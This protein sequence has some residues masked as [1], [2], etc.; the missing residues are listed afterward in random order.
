MKLVKPTKKNIHL[1]LAKCDAPPKYPIDSLQEFVVD[2][3]FQ[4]YRD[5]LTAP[6]A[7]PFSQFYIRSPSSPGYI[8]KRKYGCKNKAEAL[9]HPKFLEHFNSVELP[10][11]RDY[12]GKIELLDLNAILNDNKIR[13]TF[14]EHIDSL[15]KEKFL[16][17][18]Q[19]ANIKASN[20]TKWIKAG[21]VKQ[22]GGFNRLA[23]RLER[24][25]FKETGDVKGWDRLVCLIFVYQLRQR[26]LLRK[27]DCWLKLAYMLASKEYMLVLCHDGIVRI[28][29]TGVCSGDNN[30]TTDNCLA[31]L[32][33][34]MRLYVKLY[35]HV[36][37]YYPTLET[38]LSL[39]ETAIYSDDLIASHDLDTYGITFDEFEHFKL[40]TYAEF[41]LTFKAEQTFLV[42]GS[43]TPELKFLGSS[44]WK[45]EFM[46]MYVP[47]A[48]RAR[49]CSNIVSPEVERDNF[50]DV[51]IKL[52]GLLI[53]SS[54]D[55][56][57]FMEVRSFLIFLSS[58]YLHRLAE[59]PDFFKGICQNPGKPETW[60]LFLLGRQSNWRRRTENII[61]IMSSRAENAER[62][63]NKVC[64]LRGCTDTGVIWL[65][66]ALDP[67]PDN[68][69]EL[70]GF[71]DTVKTPSTVQY[72]R[73]NLS[74]ATPS[75][76]GV[77]WDCAIW[78]PGWEQQGNLRLTTT[79]NG[80]AYVA[81]GQGTAYA[82]GI[83]EVRAA[84][85]GT[86]LSVA[87][88][89]NTIVPQVSLVR[90]HRIVAIGIEC[91]NTTGELYKQ[92]GVITFRQDPIIEQDVAVLC[93]TLTTK[94]TPTP[95]T[96]YNNLPQSASQALLLAG[97]LK[98]EA[99][100]GTY[101]VGTLAEPTNKIHSDATVVGGMGMISEGVNQFTGDI[102]AGTNYCYEAVRNLP[103]N[104]NAFGSYFT[105]LS[106]Q[107]TI[108]VV[109]H[110]I[111][112]RFPL[113]TDTDLI[114]MAKP[115][116]P[117][118]P[119]ALEAYCK[120]AGKL[121]TGTPVGNNNWGEWLSA[122]ASVAKE[123][124]PP[125]VKGLNGYLN[126]EDV[127]LEKKIKEVADKKVLDAVTGAFSPFHSFVDSLPKQEKPVIWDNQRPRQRGSGSKAS[128]KG[129][130]R[131]AK[132]VVG[133]RVRPKM[134]G[135]VTLLKEKIR[136]R[137]EGQTKAE[138]NNSRPVGGPAV[139]NKELYYGFKPSQTRTLPA[140][141]KFVKGRGLGVK[142]TWG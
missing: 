35:Y 72:F 8:F 112:E 133:K 25:K 105:G 44:F 10:N 2:L 64:K 108:D 19:N 66:N 26:G 81:A 137:A 75:L 87:T 11:V 45:W 116:I 30:T 90:G 70:V 7:D 122:I 60:M 117:Y 104:Y 127:A 6:V 95:R 55:E 83:V 94:A 79:E 132:K 12:N 40:A 29:K 82:S 21:F 23:R 130:K 102:T 129:G 5:E 69:R 96:Y 65:K 84:A 52:V 62:F 107:S 77:N 85:S 89:V 98:W 106:T 118:D 119:P 15:M 111:I 136:K 100:K 124:I 17:D 123:V 140:P 93:A 97:S 58:T 126:P 14:T 91:F 67:F 46:D 141:R 78:H 101:C 24:F 114:T 47:G 54:P 71:P 27:D 20:E 16:F 43:L 86:A 80:I 1:S 73:E 32:V 76:G 138:M 36:F 74:I 99:E 92:G 48:S 131:V 57:L 139:I 37:G 9:S 142:H 61:F 4:Y 109:L 50:A 115:S 28:R 134:A 3:C 38:I 110:Y 121:P 41:G 53:V 128:S 135:N 33:I 18:K 68:T 31:H 42:H 51:M 56:K 125:L 22:F 13:G 103:S 63:L 88:I 120:L 34:R 49:V 39:H 59:F 113:V